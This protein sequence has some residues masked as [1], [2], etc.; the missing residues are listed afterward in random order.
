MS[1]TR[2]PSDNFSASLTYPKSLRAE[3]LDYVDFGW[4]EYA[5]NNTT[6]KYG[7]TLSD[8]PVLGSIRLYMPEST[9]AMQIGNSWNTPGGDFSGPYGKL[10][11]QLAAKAANVKNASESIGENAEGIVANQLG[12]KAIAAVTGLQSASQRAALNR[13]E[14]YNPNLELLYD[15]PTLREFNFQFNFTP[16][17]PEEAAEIRRIIRTFKILSSPEDIGESMFKIPYVW[18][19]RYRHEKMMG[20]FQPAA[21]LSVNHQ[22]NSSSPY[23]STFKDFMPTQYTLGLTFKE[24]DII[25][26]NDIRDKTDADSVG[27]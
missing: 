12:D 6:N 22:A 18:Q 16:R 17:D 3:D 19:V 7:I 26:R 14:V 4:M 23:H 5:P 25:T 21:C 15:A 9:P 27:Y 8:N 20:K 1:P 10:K 2:P 24:V 11:L 13:G